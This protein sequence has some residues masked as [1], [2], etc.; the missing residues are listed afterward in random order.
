[1]MKPLCFWLGLLT[2]AGATAAPVAVDSAASRIDIDVKSTAGS[3]VGQ[4]AAYDAM[5]E[6][7]D[8]GQTVRSAVVTFD[9]NDVQTG[10]EKR[11]KHMHAWQDTPQ[12]PA[13]RFELEELVSAADSSTTAKGALTFHGQTHL[14]EF[15]VTVTTA[16]GRFTVAGEA[17]IDTRDYGLPIIRKMLMLRVNP[18]VTVR[19]HLEG[20]MVAAN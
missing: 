5:I 16:A 14:L 7:D 19:F 11:D 2:A 17:V 1:M 9:F 3:F 18:E 13:G 20:D 6:L 8:A 12:F 4:L 10:E 15:P